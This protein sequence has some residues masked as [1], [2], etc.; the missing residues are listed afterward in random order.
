MICFYSI[1]RMPRPLSNEQ[2]SISLLPEPPVLRQSIL[3]ARGS[4]RSVP[5]ARGSTNISIHRTCKI[6][7]CTYH[8]TPKSPRFATPYLE[9]PG[10]AEFSSNVW[11]IQIRNESSPR[12]QPEFFGL[13]WFIQK[14]NESSR[15]QR[16]VQTVDDNYFRPYRGLTEQSIYS[17]SIFIWQTRVLS[18]EIY[19]CIY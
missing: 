4:T 6:L 11:S 14:N 13:S 7:T 18:V 8:G 12:Q 17:E 5:F 10:S 19:S 16:P 3:F 9:H 1:E 15:R 2:C